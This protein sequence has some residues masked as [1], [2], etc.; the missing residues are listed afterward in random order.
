MNSLRFY[1]CSLVLLVA[2]C[3]GD[4]MAAR[5]HGGHGSRGHVRFGVVVGG[6]VFSPWY[7]PSSYYYPSYA[8]LFIDQ[9]PPVYIEQSAPLPAQSPQ[10]ETTNSWYYCEASKAYYPYVKE[11]PSGWQKVL[12]QPP[13]PD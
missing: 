11:C 4:V 8:P 7:Y 9:S 10:A 1:K 12:P 3:A 6:P 13:N 2:L 5:G